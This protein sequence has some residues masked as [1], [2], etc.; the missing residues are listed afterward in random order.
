M[1]ETLTFDAAISIIVQRCNR[2]QKFPELLRSSAN[3][4]ATSAAQ[5]P[6]PVM[7]AS[8]DSIIQLQKGCTHAR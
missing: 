2:L 5:Q 3:Q 8:R 1:P 7:A 6:A 4:A